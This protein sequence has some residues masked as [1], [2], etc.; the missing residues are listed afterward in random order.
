MNALTPHQI[1]TL[2]A[3]EL[4]DQPSTALFQLKNDAA[5]LLSA[6]KAIGE[7]IDRALSI[8]YTEQA[9]QLRLA[10]GKDTG[11]V[12]F[13]DGPVRISA[14][15]SKKV[16]WDQKQLAVIAQRIAENGEKPA[17]YIELTYKVSESKYNA[18]PE[19][20]RT[21]FSP[22]RTLKPGKPSFRLARLE[23]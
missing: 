15:L 1:M 22:A 4:A 13:N 20:I 8:K 17:E 6:A 7:H 14:E 12:H 5:D 2:S 18:W 21:A 10:A 3:S 19:T 23:D 9:H 16:E 11:I